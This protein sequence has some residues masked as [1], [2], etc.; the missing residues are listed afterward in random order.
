MG[1][2]Q[3][4]IVDDVVFEITWS[5]GILISRKMSDVF[6]EEEIERVR[7]MEWIVLSLPIIV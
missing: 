6:A 3:L 4:Q 7:R 1:I 2:C 5:D